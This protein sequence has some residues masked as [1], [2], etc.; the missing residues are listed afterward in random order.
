MNCRIWYIY[1]ELTQ[2]Y[3]L[4]QE[5][6]ESLYLIIYNLL[7]RQILYLNSQDPSS[8]KLNYILIL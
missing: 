2:R 7:I 4:I 5:I 8:L 6:S 3:I 1:Q